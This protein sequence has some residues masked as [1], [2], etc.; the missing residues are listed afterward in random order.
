M[1]ELQR[2]IDILQLK[3][4]TYMQMQFIQVFGIFMILTGTFNSFLKH[5]HSPSTFIFQ[6]YFIDLIAILAYVYGIYYFFAFIYCYRIRQLN[7]K[8]NV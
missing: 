4:N 8:K 6:L 5:F 7:A 1:N 2:N 3:Q